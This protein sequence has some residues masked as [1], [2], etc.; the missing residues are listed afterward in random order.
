MNPP[1]VDPLPPPLL[2]VDLPGDLPA[3][4]LLEE[5]DDEPSV[6]LSLLVEAHT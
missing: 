3:P 6:L 4:P 2:E 1:L 5:E